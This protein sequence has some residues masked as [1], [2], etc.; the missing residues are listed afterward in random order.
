[1]KFVLFIFLILFLNSCSQKLHVRSFPSGAQVKVVDLSGDKEKVMGNTPINLKVDKG[2][3]SM[4]ILE[5]ELD[6]YRSKK[7]L[8]SSIDG[9]NVKIDTKLEVLSEYNERISKAVENVSNQ[10]KFLK[11]FLDKEEALGE[12]IKDSHDL[13]I[14]TQV[15]LS[16]Y[17]DMLFSQKYSKGIASFDRGRF[18]TIVELVSK[19][20]KYELDKNIKEAIALIKE[21]IELDSNNAYLNEYLAELYKLNN[22]NIEYKNILE[23]L[24]NLKLKKAYTS[25][26]N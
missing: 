11:D 12:A 9:T 8:V 22:N 7:I 17:K 6:K 26:L 16:L 5:F 15:E 23:K 24:D 10:Q 1:M 19:A 13:M 25:Y 2:F 4:F 18:E 21:A 14:K 3:G 20:K